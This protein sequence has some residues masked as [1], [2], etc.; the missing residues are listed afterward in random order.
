MLDAVVSHP[1]CH[2]FF[3]EVLSLMGS[4]PADEQSGLINSE[5]IETLVTMLDE[6]KTHQVME[7]AC[8]AICNIAGQ[9]PELSRCFGAEGGLAMLLGWLEDEEL[10]ESEEV[11]GAACLTVGL[12]A[13][14]VPQNE[15]LC[16]EAG[17]A[18]QLL[19]VMELLDESMQVQENAIFALGT[20]GK[21]PAGRAAIL[22]A[23]GIEA[24]VLGLEAYQ[25]ERD[26]VEKATRALFFVGQENPIAKTRMV[27]AGIPAALAAIIPKHASQATVI[28][29]VGGVIS[30]LL[31][32]ESS[33]PRRARHAL[34][35]LVDENIFALLLDVLGTFSTEVGINRVVLGIFSNFGLLAG[36][37]AELVRR[38]GFLDGAS[39]PD[40]DD[41]PPLH[42]AGTG[43]RRI[44]DAM[45]LHSRS[46][47]IL[48][49]GC[50]AIWCLAKA[51]NRLKAAI[52]ESGAIEL[53]LK[54]LASF[55]HAARYCETACA[56]LWCLAF[57]DPSNK[58]LIGGLGGMEAVVKALLDHALT[59]A[60]DTQ[61]VEHG[62]IA[63][64]NL[65]AN[66]RPNRRIAGQAGAVKAVL[67]PLKEN[68]EQADWPLTKSHTACNA[69]LALLTDEPENQYRFNKAKGRAVIATLAQK[70]SDKQNVTQLTSMLLEA[71]PET[72][73]AIPRPVAL[74]FGADAYRLFLQQPGTV[75]LK[76]LAKSDNKV[77]L[78]KQ[79]IAKFSAA[80]KEPKKIAKWRLVV[81]DT[82]DLTVY[83][84]EDTSSFGQFSETVI[85]Y[86][87]AKVEST[88][89][90]PQFKAA[91][92]VENSNGTKGTVVCESSDDAKTW[93]QAI[94]ARLPK[95][96]GSVRVV[97]SAG[98]K[99]KAVLRLAYV[100]EYLCCYETDKE[101]RQ[102]EIIPAQNMH[103]VRVDQKASTFVLTTDLK[104]FSF[105]PCT[106]GA[107]SPAAEAAQWESF[108]LGEISAQQSL[109]EH[110]EAEARAEADRTKKTQS[111][112]K[113]D[114]AMESKPIGDDRGAEGEEEER[115]LAET[116]AVANEG[117]PPVTMSPFDE[118]EGEDGE[119]THDGSSQ[120]GVDELDLLEG[121]SVEIADE[122]ER[123]LE[124]SMQQ[125]AESESVAED[126]NKR[127]TATKASRKRAEARLE[128]V[129]EEIRRAKADQA[130]TYDDAAAIDTS[131][132]GK[133]NFAARF[134]KF[135][136]IASLAA[137]S[138]ESPTLLSTCA[139]LLDSEPLCQVRTLFDR[140]SY[141][142]RCLMQARHAPR[143][144]PAPAR[145]LA[146]PM[147]ATR[148]HAGRKRNAPPSL[149]RSR[150]G[151]LTNRIIR[152]VKCIAKVEF[153]LKTTT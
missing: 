73:E 102:V 48:E 151:T 14:D 12:L 40:G 49:S 131:S 30:M 90:L 120:E 124:D 95:K 15:R 138:S 62:N 46:M 84:D 28:E 34:D 148:Q 132:Y 23:G 27:T 8:G 99:E 96:A 72:N 7:N 125:L 143:G 24:F 89:V 17:A 126:L 45:R 2:S 103:T 43:V 63:I 31:E 59:A 145:A 137:D 134:A 61:M 69:L 153:K 52:R 71:V 119:D 87:L 97:N 29:G 127:L 74:T 94:T 47:D 123:M 79:Q 112:A 5:D 100:H 111:R 56:A 70:Y 6:Y 128:R 121:Y 83:G 36:K 18:A 107:E 152:F 133:S 64:A 38:A 109:R 76:P 149:S 140:R 26:Y 3:A 98:G 16:H 65:V 60:D 10:I 104:E 42:P 1:K 19:G 53:I 141:F 20:L 44:V 41:A 21:T 39:A 78:F 81:L 75:F 86:P 68:M 146:T 50:N 58:T 130:H 11:I 101:G 150:S 139:D 117:I 113:E 110:R 105:A 122:L 147:R 22:D 54:G 13:A 116:T 66:H 82:F 77:V 51:E 67:T 55:N 115:G 33:G 35:A 142:D 32:K 129:M 88:H 25:D 57:K 118:L 80:G 91:F 136:S 85:H 4:M 37:D 93:V 92:V 135:E 9:N 106:L 144:S 114:S 108:L